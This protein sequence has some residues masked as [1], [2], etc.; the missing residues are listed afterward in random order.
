MNKVK[1]SV[2]ICSEI[3]KNKLLML[4]QKVSF[5][6]DRMEIFDTKSVCKENIIRKK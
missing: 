1:S 6:F 2:T 5:T 4:L 3:L